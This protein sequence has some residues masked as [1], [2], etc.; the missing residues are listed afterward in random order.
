MNIYFI[1]RYVTAALVIITDRMGFCKTAQGSCMS[2]TV[3]SPLRFR[4][5]NPQTQHWHLRT[6][7]RCPIQ[8]TPPAA[9]PDPHKAPCRLLRA[10]LDAVAVPPTEFEGHEPLLRDA[11][12][13][14]EKCFLE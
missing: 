5:A 13:L 1:L 8:G 4:G 10:L 14:S 6:A 11:R 12:G 9:Q 7:A 2:E 3:R